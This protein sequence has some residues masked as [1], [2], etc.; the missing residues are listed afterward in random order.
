MERAVAGLGDSAAAAKAGFQP[1]FG[2][3]PTMG[4]HWV[5]P[6]RMLS[7]T[8]F[9]PAA[10]AQ[11]MFSRLHGRTTLVGVAYAYFAPFGDTTRPASFEGNPPVARA[12]RSGAPRGHPGDAACLGGALARRA[13]CRA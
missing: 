2:W 7:P 3:I 13:V 1:M 4:T 6:L 5:N 8:P 10:P 12:S 9:E 11:L